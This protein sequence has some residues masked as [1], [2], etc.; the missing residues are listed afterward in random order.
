[1]ADRSAKNPLLTRHGE[2]LDLFTDRVHAIRPDQWDAPTPCTEW[3][4]RDLVNHL[5]AEQ[6]WVPPLVRDGSTIE[7]QGDA[8]DGD[9]LGD[10]PVAAWDRAAAEARAAFRAP[11]AIERTVHLSY[12]ETPASHYCA[13]MITDAVVH[14]WDLSRGIGADE[15]LPAA[16]VTF[17]VREITPYAADLEKSGLFAAPVEPPAGADVQ[18]KLLAL[19]GR[20][21]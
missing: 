12:G 16:L 4:V 17:S 10:D 2:A 11:G 3:S 15:R 8:F 20:R 6:L 1:M 14:A 13:Q 18:T 21:V 19:L 5:T 7:A 9:V